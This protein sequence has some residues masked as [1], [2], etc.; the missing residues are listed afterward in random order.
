MGGLKEAGWDALKLGT[1]AAGWVCIEEGSRRLGEP[2]AG[3]GEILA[4]VG[5]AGVF[6]AV[7][8]S[9]V[10]LLCLICNSAPKSPFLL[11]SALL[12]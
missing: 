4:G 3:V 11:A 1:A 8:E 10:Y 2:V 5:T 6:S 12:Y 7:C 9:L